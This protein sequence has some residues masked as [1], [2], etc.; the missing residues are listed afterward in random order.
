MKRTRLTVAMIGLATGL[1]LSILHVQGSHAGAKGCSN[2]TLDGSYGFYRFGV[3]STG[4]LAAVGLITF[5]GNGNHTGTQS[6]SRPGSM[7]PF[8]LD[9]TDP[10]SGVPV[11]RYEVDFNCTGKLFGFVSA[12]TPPTPPFVEVEAARLVVIDGG[13][14]VYMLSETTGNAVYVVGRKIQP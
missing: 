12:T 7:P 8:A 9:Q 6:I 3:T 11:G 10:P 14:G 13:A 1:L 4:P 5:D 2:D